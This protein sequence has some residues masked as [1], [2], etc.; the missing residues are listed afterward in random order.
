MTQ[1][2][3]DALIEKYDKMYFDDGSVPLTDILSELID[4]LTKDEWYNYP[5][6]CPDMPNMIPGDPE[7]GWYSDWLIVKGEFMGYRIAMLEW[8]PYKGHTLW[9]DQ[10][11]N[12]IDKVLQWK[13]I[14]PPNT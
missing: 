6:K 9:K 4:E 8:D 2:E 14:Q 3:K 7:D 10:E 12:E 13:H 11:G 5:E 1:Q